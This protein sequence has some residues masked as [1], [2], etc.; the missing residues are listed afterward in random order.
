[1]QTVRLAWRATGRGVIE[2]YHSQN[3]TYASSIAYYALL[4][5]FPFVLLVLNVLS[6]LAIGRAGDEQAVVHLVAR[7]LPSGFDLLSTQGVQLQRAP[8]TLTIAGAVLTI[9][10]SMGVFGAI[11]SAVNHAWGTEKPWGYF[12]HKAMAFTMM[13]TAAVVFAACLLVTGAVQASNTDWFAN[14]QQRIPFLSDFT[15]FVARY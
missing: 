15:G 8:V 2:F 6:R 13:M 4:S 9:W 14:L 5:M 12:K 3:L 1:M 11:T 7:A 10:A